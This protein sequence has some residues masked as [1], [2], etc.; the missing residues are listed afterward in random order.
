L[1]YGFRFDDLAFQQKS[2]RREIAWAFLVGACIRGPQ[3]GRNAACIR[4]AVYGRLV[5]KSE[6]IDEI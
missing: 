2:R 3:P 4:L 6:R 5:L 1:R